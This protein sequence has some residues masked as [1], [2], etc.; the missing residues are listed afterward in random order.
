M[1]LQSERENYILRYGS[2]SVIHLNYRCHTVRIVK[3]DVGRRDGKWRLCGWGEDAVKFGKQVYCST[4]YAKVST[5]HSLLTIG[6]KK[7]LLIY[8]HLNI[9]ELWCVNGIQ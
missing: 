5:T 9:I 2:S 3:L 4:R 6:M 1:T 8:I 7:Q